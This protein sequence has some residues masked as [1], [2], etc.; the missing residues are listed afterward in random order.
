MQLRILAYILSLDFFL[1]SSKAH[2]ARDKR[3]ILEYDRMLGLAPAVR[4]S[5]VVDLKPRLAAMAS[6]VFTCRS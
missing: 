4:R 3:L 5:S 1:A 2:V 6:A